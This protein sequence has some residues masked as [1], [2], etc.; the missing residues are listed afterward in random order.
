M[1]KVISIALALLMVAVMLPV[2]AMA[3]ESTEVAKLT[4]GGTVTY[5]NSLVDAVK[6]AIDETDA[7]IDVLKS[8]SGDGIEV[9]HPKKLDLTIDFQGHTYDVSGQA[10][11]SKGYESQAW[12]IEK[13]SKLTLMNGTLEATSPHVA[14]LFQ[15]YSDLTLDNMVLNAQKTGFDYTM[16]NNNG[17]LTVK[18]NSKIIAADGKN[19]FDLWYGMHKDYY[20]GV[21]VTFENF[22]GAVVGN[23]E[24]G[25]NTTGATANPDWTNKTSLSIDGGTFTGQLKKGNANDG[26]NLDD[27][28]ISI[29]GG[30]FN[31]DVTSY[32]GQDT[33]AVT[34]GSNY[35]VGGTARDAVQN[36]TG[37]TF[38]IKKAERGTG[39]NNVK[40]GVTI[41]NNSGTNITV[42]GNEVNLDDTYTV[43]GAPIIIYTPDN[44]PAIL[45]GANQVVAPG[46]AATFRIDEEYSR[47][48][49]VAVDGVTLDKSNYEAWS[50]S[51][52]IKLLPKFM[53]TL[54][55][56]THTLTA[57]FTSHTVSTT[58][59]ISEGAK[60]PATGANDFVG[61]AAA[62][63][64]ISLLGAAAVI[65]KK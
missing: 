42:N 11:G 48:L 20:N 9:K 59:T 36:A 58:F 1:K 40:P 7:K 14:M 3:D 63:A 64:V 52:Y 34:D 12:H 62:M 29:T 30:T 55:V 26:L 28:N 6:A 10:V 33:L 41:V 60:N 17:S 51:T 46:A 16:S 50:G 27:A 39:F 22:T 47:L 35:Y 13:E 8:S 57:Y 54:S 65:R 44:E 31:T 15:N 53:K 45:S 32:V 2:M 4:I 25:A 56:G 5:Y 37:G 49:A 18:G 23:I 21:S 24:Y 19:A 61:V 38:T 43:P